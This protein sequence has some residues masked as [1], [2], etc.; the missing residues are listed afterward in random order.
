VTEET[1]RLSAAK[2]LSRENVGRLLELAKSNSR[3]YR[4]F[5]IAANTGL[6]LSEIIHLRAEDILGNTSMEVT[7]LKR[8]T[9]KSEVIDLPHP[10]GQMLKKFAD[11]IKGGWLFIG[12][13][14]PCKKN[15][16]YICTGGHVSG[17]EMQRVWDRYLLKLK[18]SKPG[19]GIHTL[20]HYAGTEFYSATKDLRATQEFLGHAS[21]KTTET[22][23]HVVDMKKKLSEVKPT[24]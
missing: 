13:A 1:W 11:E 8:A 6:R 12:A 5:V 22:Y 19:R 18:L 14:K 24:L 15:G 2:L 23:A 20:R 7:R 17:R 3:D 9:L 10:L 21:S 4:F 16:K